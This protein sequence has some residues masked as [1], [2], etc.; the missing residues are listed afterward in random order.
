MTT[1]LS[2]LEQQFGLPS[3]L[4]SAVEQQESGGDS[5]AVSPKGALG[6]FQ[7]MPATAQQYGIDPTDPDQSAIGAAKMYS[8]LLNKYQGDIP[9]ALA[10]YNW[11]QGNVDKQGLPNA[12]PETKN[13]IASV[14]GKIGNAIVPSAQAAEPQQSGQTNPYENLSDQDL[15]AEAKKQ[16]IQLPSMNDDIGAKAELPANQQ[17]QQADAYVNSTPQQQVAQDVKEQDGSAPKSGYDAMSDEQLVT[18]AKKQGIDVAAPQ[19]NSKL[20]VQNPTLKNF[21]NAL[22]KTFKDFPSEVAKPYED[23]GQMVYGNKPI[24]TDSF[25]Q[26][27]GNLMNLAMPFLATPEGLSGGLTESEGAALP[28]ASPWDVLSGALK[29]EYEKP[30]AKGITTPQEAKDV[31]S[32]YYKQAQEK[33]GVIDNPNPLMDMFQGKDPTTPTEI[34]VAKNDPVRKFAMDFSDVRS[35]PMTL[36]DAQ[37]LDEE[38]SNRIGKEYGIGGLSK[39]GQKLLE[40]QSNFRE[41]LKNTPPETVG[42]GAEGYQAWKNGQKAWQQAMKLQDLDNIQTRA[43]LSDNP[44]TAI[45]SGIRTLL[46]SP[47]RRRGYSP[48][49]I[50]ALQNAADRGA[51][52][53]TL[54]VFGSRL[55]PMGAAFIGESMGGLPGAAISGLMGHGLSSVLRRGASSIQ[56]SKMSGAARIIGQGVPKE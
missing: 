9:S 52:G 10:A 27:A 18:E 13:Y 42:G 15:L 17:V 11:G 38:L 5:N 24:I 26:T 43:D 50:K 34:A 54:H 3:G 28:K 8:D 35:S 41:A 55:I 25:G 37:I 51:L 31:A 32:N 16:G 29:N 1:N 36:S 19:S 7:F 4:L 44:A 30:E 49:E 14:M 40:A 20:F 23:I 12:P 56:S 6:A 53:S 45:K 2:Q 22:M 39:D 33:G 48:Q 46:S 21:G 47:S